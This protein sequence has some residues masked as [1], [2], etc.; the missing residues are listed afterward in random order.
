M[1]NCLLPAFFTIAVLM[2]RNGALAVWHV[3]DAAGVTP[4]T[5]LLDAHRNK[6]LQVRTA[7][8]ESSV[9][10]GSFVSSDASGVVTMWRPT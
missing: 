1:T 7:P 10:R 6:I 2:G 8:R 4:A 3:D 5:S 9:P